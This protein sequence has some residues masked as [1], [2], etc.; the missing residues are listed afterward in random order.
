MY[1]HFQYIQYIPQAIQDVD[2]FVSL[3]ENIWRNFKSLAHQWILCDHF[4][5]WVNY[6]FKNGRFFKLILLHDM[7][8]NQINQYIYAVKICQI[9]YYCGMWVHHWIAL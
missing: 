8:I 4:H 9:L 3:S 1:S 2:E 7:Q 6:S 5:F